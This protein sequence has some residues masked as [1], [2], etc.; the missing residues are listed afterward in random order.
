MKERVRLEEKSVSELM[1]LQRYLTAGVENLMKNIVKVSLKNPAQGIFMSRFVKTVQEASRKRLLLEK[2]GEHVPAF[3]IASITS[4]CNLHCNGCYARAIHSCTDTGS[5]E[6]LSAQEWGRIFNE[7]EELGISFIILAGGEPMIRRDVIEMAGS[8]RKILFPIFTNGTLFDDTYILLL[9]KNRNLI[10]IFSIEG[11]ERKTDARRGGGVYGKVLSAMEKLQKEKLL[12]ASSVT[13]TKDNLEE[14]TSDSFVKRLEERG[15]RALF[16]VEFVPME[17]ELKILAPG[18]KEREYLD[19][20][21]A[22]IRNQYPNMIFLS[23]PGDEKAAG[24]CI[25]AGR[26]FFH[27]NS[28][29]GAEPCPF[30]PYFDVNVRESSL[31]EAL[32]SDLFMK[33]QAS[34]TLT[35]NHVGGCVLFEN[36]DKVE[37]LIHE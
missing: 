37:S 15:C 14:V 11:K 7:A 19:Y 25:A 13:V 21:L 9:K 2:G 23:F 32:H 34:G 3:L 18:E 5:V 10:P 20:H 17:P 31:R 36:S 28:H 1:D 12:F 16:F 30:S 33:L 4:N 24:G 22:K 27:I 8:N 35:E 26:G 6:Q 29:G